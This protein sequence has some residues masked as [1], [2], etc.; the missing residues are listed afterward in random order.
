MS[1][2]SHR[3]VLEQCLRVAHATENHHLSVF[4][5]GTHRDKEDCS[6][7]LGKKNKLI[8]KEISS[9]HLVFK[10]G[11]E[12]IW[13][14][15][16]KTPDDNDLSVATQLRQAI[17]KRCHWTTASLPMKW[18]QFKLQIRDAAIRDVISFSSC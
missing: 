12:L 6:E 10:N 8:A 1:P 7:K 13:E 17:V 5:V 18:F 16:G 14:I 2:Y 11:T 9:R 4:V 15:N 3:Q